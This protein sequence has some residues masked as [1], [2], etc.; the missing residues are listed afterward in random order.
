MAYDSAATRTRLLDAAY[1][2]FVSVGMAGA[3]VDRIATA[4]TA[5]KQAIY[6]YFGSKDALFDAVLESRLLVLADLV[7][8]TPHD[9]PGYIAALFDQLLTDP[10]LLRLTQW[11]ALERPNASSGEVEAHLDKA[12]ALAEAHGVD[13]E[14]AMDAMMLALSATQSWATTAPAI[15]N[16]TNELESARL[17]RHRLALIEA[18][19]AI[20]DALLRPGDPSSGSIT[21]R[22]SPCASRSGP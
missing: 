14:R 9:F 15:R 22:D 18:V 19:A 3:R 16:P 5:N 13:R 20:A 11:K 7:P 17:A 12:A 2:E 4:A 6:A 10:G 1:D 21:E 8:F